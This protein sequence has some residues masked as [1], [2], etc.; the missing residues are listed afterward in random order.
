MDPRSGAV[1]TFE[2]DTDA[3]AAGYT[4]PVPASE[5]ERVRAMSREERKQW[6]TERGYTLHNAPHLTGRNRAA[7]RG[8]AGW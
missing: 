8:D 4:V 5:E 3:K 7:R 6:A 1:A 2:N